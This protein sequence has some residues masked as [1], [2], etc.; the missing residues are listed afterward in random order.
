ML[1]PP[2]FYLSFSHF[3][4]IR[5]IL[6]DPWFY[7]NIY[8]WSSPLSLGLTSAFNSC[9]WAFL[10]RLLLWALRLWMYVPGIFQWGS[11][12]HDDW[13]LGD[14][15]LCRLGGNFFCSNKLITICLLASAMFDKLCFHCCFLCSLCPCELKLFWL[16]Y[17]T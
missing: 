7:N 17:C 12:K 3:W 4:G 2:G 6:G 13:F 5:K 1:F 9:M 15:V 8:N 16:S 10:P 11:K 14:I